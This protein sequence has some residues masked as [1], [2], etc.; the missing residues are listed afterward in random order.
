MKII[1]DEL[2]YIYGVMYIPPTD[3]PTSVLHF[4]DQSSQLTPESPIHLCAPHATVTASTCIGR[5][6]LGL[7]CWTASTNHFPGLPL[8]QIG[9]RIAAYYA[10]GQHTEASNASQNVA[11][12]M[13]S[14]LKEEGAKAGGSTARAKAGGSTAR[15]EC[16]RGP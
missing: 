3:L 9:V 11:A 2:G 5:L 15:A 7:G 14:S 12:E 8:R 6:G 13:L 1:S 4:L 10:H 16:L